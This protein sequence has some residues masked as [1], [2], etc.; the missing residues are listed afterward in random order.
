VPV[1]LGDDSPVLGQADGMFRERP[2][3]PALGRHFVSAWFYHR[4]F[5]P[6]R[7][8]AVVPDTYADL[9]W[10]DGALLVAGPDR[11]VSFESVSPGTTVVGLRFKP[12]AVRTWLG[13]PASEIVGE[14]VRLD[15][16]R[17]GQANELRDAIGDADSP[18][19]VA[20]RLE[21]AL[22]RTAGPLELPDRSCELVLKLIGETSCNR[23]IMRELAS[24][25]GSSERTVRR[26]CEQAFGYGPKT[27]DRILRMQ[28]FLR[29]AR[30]QNA[31]GL[32]KLAAAAGYAD[33]AHLTR[34]ARELTG[35][36][37]KMIVDQL[38]PSKESDAPTA[39]WHQSAAVNTRPRPAAIA[40]CQA[41]TIPTT[42]PP[43][44]AK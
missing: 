35:M 40:D 12:G 43:G 16:F 42:C 9:I 6:P 26:H 28:R 30:L 38:A 3:A 7:R 21:K 20:G 29:L 34:E 36:T 22:V 23:P 24:V 44:T 5:G 27:L 33:Q 19:I 25:L 41:A 14:R 1:D 37:P 2:V 15:H 11:T 18:A 17:S 4:P 31:F 8:T 13:V 39:R 10:F 32:A